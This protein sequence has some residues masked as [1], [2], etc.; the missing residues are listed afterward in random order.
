MSWTMCIPVPK[1]STTIDGSRFICFI[2][3]QI[4][5]VQFW[6][7]PPDPPFFKH[8]SF[9]GERVRYLQALATIDH[10]AEKLPADLSHDIQRSV[11]AHMQTL[12]Q[13]LGVGIELSRH[14]KG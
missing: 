6:P 12:G 3:P 2:I 5:P 7:N 13:K 4:V 14:Q 10:L 8:P 1:D 9:D 11:A